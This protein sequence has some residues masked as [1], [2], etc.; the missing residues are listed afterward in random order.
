MII[1]LSRI[2]AIGFEDTL[3][4]A[5]PISG[6]C[7][8]IGAMDYREIVSG[9]A[10]G[11]TASAARAGLTALEAIYAPVVA[12]RNCWY[13][14]VPGAARR[15]D[16]P[17]VSVG[18]VTMG[19]TGKTPLTAA[20]VE[21][22]VSRGVKTAIISR[23]YHAKPG[24]LND[25]GKELTTRIPDCIYVQNPKRAQAAAALCA[26]ASSR[27]Q[28]IVL[29]DGFQHRRLARQLDIVLVDAL[30]PF[31][32]NRICPRGFLRES[33]YS[34]RRAQCVVITR[35][36]RVS[37]SEL[38]QIEQ[39]VLSYNRNLILARACHRPGVLR[40]LSGQT[41]QLYSVAGKRVMAFCGLG[42]P[43]AFRQTVESLDCN[44]AAFKAYPDHH[45]YSA[46][47]EK[48]ITALA[49]EVKADAVVCTMKDFVKLSPALLQA[50]IPVY[51]I[52]I[53]MAFL[54]GEAEFW[55]LVDSVIAE[56]C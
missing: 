8:I 24:E 2:C 32:Y 38:E 13:D 9:E 43:D 33:L 4:I 17:V 55:T 23:G 28:L 27:P 20:V 5:L 45:L 19:G 49:E 30:N 15:V 40:R 31:G 11:V 41:E 6:M 10:R 29:D 51:G 14:F 46:S 56:F 48:E 1:P 35:A 16:V 54:S 42:N 37:D 7:G 25:E 34:L 18:N 52:E 22:A 50:P 36:D 44:I 53:E 3:K 26:E 47:D 21:R 39:Q 12:L